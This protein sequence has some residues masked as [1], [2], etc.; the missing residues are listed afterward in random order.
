MPGAILTVA[1]ATHTIYRKSYGK[2]TYNNQIHD[3]EV[4][5]NTKYDIAS[6]TKV[7]AAT[8]SIMQ[9]MSSNS[10]KLT[11]PITKF[12]SNY[13]VNKKGNT[14]IANL[15]LHNSGQKY[16]YPG[17]LPKTTDEVINYIVFAKPDNPVGTA[18]QYSNLGF[19]LLSLIVSKVRGV[20]FEQYV[21][22]NNIFAGLTNTGFNPPQ[23]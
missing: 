23:S 19:L 21:K 10:I 12:Y 2:L 8:Y 5:N 18:F 13:D 20:S 6:I 14:T 7:M 17:A 9:L 22:Q 16:D 4:N 3:V 15:L 1:N 11:D